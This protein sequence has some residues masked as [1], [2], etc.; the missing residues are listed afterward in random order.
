MI[1]ILSSYSNSLIIITACLASIGGTYL[2]RGIAIRNQLLA[3]P[4]SRAMHVIPTPKG[5]GIVLAVVFIVGILLLGRLQQIS[6]DLMLALSIGGGLAALLGFM[7]DLLQLS[8]KNRFIMQGC[9]VAAVLLY[10]SGNVLSVLAGLPFVLSFWLI[11]PLS[12]LFLVWLIN[13]YNFMDGIDGIAAA[14]AISVCVIAGIILL[15]TG[16]SAG[17]VWI[18]ALLAGCCLGFILFN[19]PPA[20]IFMGDA[21]S[22]FLGFCFAA[23]IVS[24]V[25]AGELSIYTWLIMLSYFLGDATTTLVIR[26]FSG[27]QWY[28]AHRSHAYQH[29]AKIYA[30]HRVVTIG[31]IAYNIVWVMP[32]AI[33][34]T[35]RPAMN[36]WAVILALL[37]PMLC[38]LRFGPWYATKIMAAVKI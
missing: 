29:L 5:G 30:S 28:V 25:S 18:F 35:V 3:T 4:N 36:I 38:A 7:D 27:Q 6:L 24:T 8:A 16:G 12:W 15:L 32:L 13:L 14:Y 37:P 26:I 17:T 2:Y 10:F 20:S 9:L 22:I 1:N 31:V 11:W 33:W 19:W 21:G 34:A 23:L